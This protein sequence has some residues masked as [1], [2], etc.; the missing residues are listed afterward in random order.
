MIK[1]EDIKEETVVAEETDKK[2]DEMDT[3]ETSKAEEDDLPAAD[4]KTVDAEEMDTATDEKPTETV[5][6]TAPTTDDN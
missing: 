1:T 5:E 6:N 3:N 4:K 2:A